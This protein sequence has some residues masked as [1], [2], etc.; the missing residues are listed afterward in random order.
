MILIAV[1]GKA[2]A[3]LIVGL[4]LNNAEFRGDRGANGFIEM[5]KAEEALRT[6]AS[7][8]E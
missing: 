6:L 2:T 4:P 7:R 8:V 1:Q 3:R 5:S